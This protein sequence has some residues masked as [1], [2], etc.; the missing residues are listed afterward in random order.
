MKKLLSIITVFLVIFVATL[1]IQVCAASLDTI[2]ITT[3]KQTVH[4]NDNV[5]VN[6]DF[7]K[8][9]GAYTV[10]IAYD[11]NLF[12]Y[13]SSEGGTENDNGTRVRV[14]YFDSTGGSKPRNNMSVT[15]K[16]KSGIT[17]S[18]PTEFSIT[19]EGLASPDASTQYDDI[20]TPIIKSV[21]VEPAYVNYSFSLKYSGDVVKNVKKDMKIGVSSTMGKNYEHTRIIA[22]VKA[23]KDATAK[24][25]ATDEQGLEHE[26]IQSGWGSAAGDKIGGKNVV[27]ELNVQGL[28]DKQGKY[29]ITLKLIDRDNSDKQIASK[30]FTVNVKEKAETKVPSTTN[31]KPSQTVNKKKPTTLPKT[32]NTIY[33]AVISIIAILTIAYITLRKRED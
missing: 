15:F 10:D 8:S 17:T 2:N 12:E 11:N 16:A 33:F 32:G 14:Y 5:K 20:T 30:T 31:K 18:N 6:V 4:P 3:S 27:K 26:I 21:I 24:L 7:G 19:A 9:L 23:P 1:S 25:L 28:F 29:E 22:E 13:V